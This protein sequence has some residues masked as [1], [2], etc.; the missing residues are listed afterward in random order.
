GTP[1]TLG[2][3]FQLA[4]Q[5]GF[6]ETRTRDKAASDAV[7][8]R[9]GRPPKH[10]PQSL[11][12]VDVDDFYAYLPAHSYLYLP[13]RE[14]WP[15]S[16][17]NSKIPPIPIT[18][19]QGS[20]VLDDKGKSKNMPA[21]AWLDANR[22]VEQMTWTPGEFELIKNY[23]IAEGGFIEHQGATTYNLYRPP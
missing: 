3:L 2:S 20:P 19:A 13:T 5:N 6:A 9:R 18:D 15:A 8:P 10:D 16:S 22:S 17:V 21:A 12:A 11:F 1:V 14:L 23:H 4:Q 7:P